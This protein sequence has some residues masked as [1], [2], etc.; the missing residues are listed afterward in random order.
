MQAINTLTRN[1]TSGRNSYNVSS[2]ERSFLEAH[3]LDGR[4]IHVGNLPVGVTEAELRE[5][6]SRF[7]NILNVDIRQ[8]P[9]KFERELIPASISCFP[10]A[11]L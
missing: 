2:D 1:S 3:E 5:L 7:G 8:Y 10:F 4:S 6:F 9:S 11:N